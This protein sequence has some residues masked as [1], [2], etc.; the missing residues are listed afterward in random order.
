MIQKA[1]AVYSVS[2]VILIALFFVA[3]ILGVLFYLGLLGKEA[4]QINCGIKL[5]DYC[6]SWMKSGYDNNARPDS[7]NK[8]DPKNCE[9][10]GIYEPAADDC[11][12]K[13]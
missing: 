13:K 10:I 4:N 7:W 5:T 2:I 12:L 9:E 8:L 3:G 11:K 1:I 6:A